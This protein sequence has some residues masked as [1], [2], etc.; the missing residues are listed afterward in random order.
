MRQ[1][2]HTK[3]QQVLRFWLLIP[4]LVLSCLRAQAYDIDYF[5]NSDLEVKFN[6]DV[7][8][9]ANNRLVITFQ[10][11]HGSNDDGWRKDE[12]GAKFYLIDGI[13]EYY[14]GN[15]RHNSDYDTNYEFI[16]SK[17]NKSGFERLTSTQYDINA[18]RTYRKP[19][20]ESD[21]NCKSK[22]YSYTSIT[23]KVP[24]S[25]LNRNFTIRIKG[26]YWRWG[27]GYK[28]QSVNVSKKITLNYDYTIGQLSISKTPSNVTSENDPG[29]TIS[30]DKKLTVYWKVGQGGNMNEHAKLY[31]QYKVSKG[32]CNWIDS[33]KTPLHI[34]SDVKDAFT[35][36]IYSMKNGY[37]D[38]KLVL[39]YDD[40][41]SK[42]VSHSKS[43][44]FQGFPYPTS[45]STVFSMYDPTVQS[46]KAIGKNIKIS[47]TTENMPTTSSDYRSYGQWVIL[48]RNKSNF[49]E[50]LGSVPLNVTSFT[51][52]MI[53]YE[54]QYQYIIAYQY[55]DW[56]M[57]LS[58]Y[59]SELSF[60]SAS[61]DT[62]RKM[63]LE[64]SS[65]SQNQQID[66]TV[67]F[68]KSNVDNLTY[69][70]VYRMRNNE[71]KEMVTRQ[72]L[73]AD[74]SSFTF[75]DV[76]STT[77][78]LDYTVGHK[79]VVEL[80]QN[81][82][83]GDVGSIIDTKEISAAVKGGTTLSGLSAT[84]GT[85]G[86]QVKLNWDVTRSEDKTVEDHYLITRRV[87]GSSENFEKIDL[88]STTAH[89]YTYTDDTATPGNYY[90]YKVG[91]VGP[92]GNETDITSDATIVA[93][94][95][96]TGT[97]T[98]HINYSQGTSVSGVTLKLDQAES[99]KMTNQF[100]SL[101]LDGGS[102]KVNIDSTLVADLFGK[103]SNFS[104]QFWAKPTPDQARSYGV[105]N[106]L[107]KFCMNLSCASTSQN[108]VTPIIRRN[109]SN[110]VLTSVS[111]PKNEW[112]HFS[113]V[114]NGAELSLTTTDL[115]GN[116]TK[117]VI[118]TT[119]SGALI[120]N[121]TTDIATFRSLKKPMLL[122]GVGLPLSTSSL[123][124][125]GQLDEFRVWSKPLTTR[126][127]AANHDHMLVG[128]EM[129]LECYLPVDE[130]LPGHIFDAST[131][132]NVAHTNHGTL[133]GNVRPSNDF[134]LSFGLKGMTDEFGNY[135]IAGVPCS[136]TGITYNV[137][138]LYGTH[139]FSPIRTQVT[140]SDHVPVA[141]NQDFTD[142]SSFKV[143]GKVTYKYGSFPVEDAIVYVDGEMAMLEGEPVKT[144]AYGEYEVDVPIGSHFIS[145]KK[146]YHEFSYN[147]RFPHETGQYYDFQEDTKEVNFIDETLVTIVGRVSG[148]LEQTQLP[149]GFGSE[150]GSKALI[151]QATI[152][153]KPVS[154]LAYLIN[155]SE[156]NDVD[157]PNHDNDVNSVTTLLR[158][159]RTDRPQIRIQT[160]S[161]TG[162]FKA[163]LPP[164]NYQIISASTASVNADDLDVS[165]ISIIKPEL[166]TL[167]VDSMQING[168]MLYSEYHAKSIIPYQSVPSITISDMGNAD[169]ALGES[170]YN[171]KKKTFPLYEI[172]VDGNVDYLL[173]HPVFESLKRYR[174]L[175]KA[176]Q[177]YIN[178]DGGI[179]IENKIP[180]RGL[181]VSFSGSSWKN[182]ADES[183]DD[184]TLNDKGLG[185]YNFIGANP[186][187]DE[188]NGAKLPLLQASYELNGRTYVYPNDPIP[189]FF[190]GTEMF[191]GQGFVTGGP[192]V[193]EFVLRDPPGSNSYA[194]VE[195]GST[196][197]S[198]TTFNFED[199][200]SQLQ[201]LE[202]AAGVK[203]SY[204][205]NLV[206]QEFELNILG[207]TEESFEST[208]TNV[209]SR[210]L[211]STTELTRTIST[212]DSEDF[213]GSEGD[214]FVGK[215]TNMLYG[216][217][218]KVG[219]FTEEPYDDDVNYQVLTSSDGKEEIY[220]YDG[221]VTT[222]GIFYST[223]FAYTA[224]HIE[225]IL[226]PELDRLRKSLLLPMGT[227]PNSL[228]WKEGEI[229]KY[230]SKVPD[231]NSNFGNPE[232][233]EDGYPIYYDIVINDALVL[234]KLNYTDRVAFYGDAINVWQQYL[235][236]NEQ[237]KVQANY[238]KDVS[239][240][241]GANYEESKTLTSG[242][243]TERSVVR[244]HSYTCVAGV[245]F[246]VAC[247][248]EVKGKVTGGKGDSETSE[249]IETEEQETSLT[250]G[251]SLSDGDAHNYFSVGVA[252]PDSI[253]GFCFHLNGGQSSCPYEGPQPTR[254]YM[255][256]HYNISSGTTQLDMPKLS[257]DRPTITDI[258]AGK[259]A[260]MVVSLTNNSPAR[261]DRTYYLSY[262]DTTN[263]NGL[264]M[265]ID[266][267]PITSQGRG[268]SV[269]AG[270]TLQKTMK[271]SQSRTDVLDYENIKL[272]LQP[273]CMLD[274]DE[275]YPSLTSE[276]DFNI[277][278]KPSCSDATMK[279]RS[280][281]D[282]SEIGTINI[283][284][285]NTLI[286]EATDFDKNFKD[287]VYIHLQ[288]KGEYET[289]WKTVVTY[290]LNDSIAQAD[291]ILLAVPADASTVQYT[292]DMHDQADQAFQFRVQTVGRYGTGFVTNESEVVTI[293]KDSS[294]PMALGQPT[295]VGGILTPDGEIS[296]IFNEDI[297][298]SK[299]VNSNIEVM[300]V[301][302]G[303][304]LT[305]ETGLK[306][307]NGQVASTEASISLSNMPFSVEMWLNR[308]MNEAA[309]LLTHG[310]GDDALS[311]SYTA[312]NKLC[313]K[314]NGETFKSDN[315][316]VTNDWQYLSVS[317]NSETQHLQAYA[318][319]NDNTGK[320]INASLLGTK[321]AVVSEPYNGNGRIALGENYTGMMQELSIWNTARTMADLSDRNVCKSGRETGLIA[322]WAM[323]ECRG[324]LAA[325]KARRRNLIIPSDSYW[326]V[327]DK[328]L[329]AHFNGSGDM[330]QMSMMN[331]PITSGDDYTLELQFHTDA[332]KGTLISC[333][334]GV[335]D[336]DTSGALSLA[337]VDG[338][339]NL[340]ANGE[341][342]ALGSKALNDNQWH[343][344]VLNV[345]Q[346][347][348]AIAYVDGIV[349][350]Q[351][352]ATS[353]S[354]L[355][356]G[357]GMLTLGADRYIDASHNENVSD[358]FRGDIDEVR[359]WKATMT[360][361]AIMLNSSSRL[362]GTEKGLALYYP[363]EVKRKIEGTGVYETVASTGDLCGRNT[364]AATGHVT[365]T[366]L[367]PMMKGVRKREAVYHSWVASD[368][369]IVISI[370]EPVSNIE[371]CTLEF[372]VDYIQD[373]NGNTLTAPITWTTFVDIN[374][375]QWG[376]TELH[377]VT[378]Q[379]QPATATV[380]ITNQ[381]SKEEVWTLTGLPA[382]LEANPSQGTLKQLSS[383]TI[384]FTTSESTPIG[385]YEGVVYLTGNNSVD[386]PLYVSLNVTGNVPDWS[387]NPNDYELSMNIIGQLQ[388]DGL[389]SEDTNDIVAAFDGTK[390]VGVSHP[391]YN[392]RY[393]SFF[394][395][396]T[397][398]GN[399][400][401]NPITLKVY[402][403]STG[404]IYPVVTTT[405]GGTARNLQFIQD[406]LVGTTRTPLLI[407]AQNKVQQDIALKNGWTWI[408]L[409]AVPD[410]PAIQT[411]VSDVA[412]NILS[413]KGRTQ[414]I[415]HSGS[416]WGGTLSTME[417]GKM[418]KIQADQNVTLSVVGTAV[419]A[420]TTPV[421]IQSGWN[422]IGFNSSIHMNVDEAFA[423]LDP[424]DGD[425]VK[426]QNSF[427]YYDQNEWIGT[428]NTMTAGTGYYYQSNRT[429]TKTFCY[430][431][432]TATS[433][434]KRVR[435]NIEPL[436]T[437]VYEGN[438]NMIAVVM[439]G[440]R[441]VDDAEVSVF[442]GT[443]LRGYSA[444]AVKDGRHFLTIGGKG[445][446]D[447]LRFMVT[448]D[449]ESRMLNQQTSYQNDAVRGSM[450]APFILQLGEATAIDEV[451][452]AQQLR[453]TL[454][455]LA[456]R[457]LTNTNT[458]G[459][460]IQSGTKVVR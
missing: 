17:E 366:T 327:S 250:F 194:Y 420:S 257:L 436:Q 111:V 48:R 75:S 421:T 453:D 284:T 445:Q 377:F 19:L 219:F 322:N 252:E 9:P 423:D 265:T 241:V 319:Y 388:V 41:H 56:D 214:V 305:H 226:L 393:D 249:D 288:Q 153:M 13:T 52:R 34:Q 85:Y 340:K 311:I 297:Y 74:Q 458:K 380:T 310:V 80:V 387:V 220:F 418:Y 180:M 106:I 156:T 76:H 129:G 213:V 5:E 123:A 53:D 403:A 338:K 29:F 174:L 451:E 147:G 96:S 428:L 166:G 378:E 383:Q 206:D 203:M 108:Y 448:C 202:F 244:S 384:T 381:S 282:M 217:G 303:Q 170:A 60:T 259:E 46:G 168:E 223:E 413:V 105:F 148:G 422:W 390:C 263:P 268:F 215:A 416:A 218:R 444:A 298:K 63:N 145:I 347:A 183:E 100:Y 68:A 308:P 331:T 90:E 274:S 198:T 272:I 139:E 210:T 222:S 192:D 22:H 449:G 65:E 228:T 238:N 392:A 124:F 407:N 73:S 397:I 333:G 395:M 402:D 6:K 269:G 107:D 91:V 260:V 307:S 208:T 137:T 456:G 179:H 432:V 427:A 225:E 136:R 116:S 164:M 398:Y 412:D 197:A 207:T 232:R 128:S 425:V 67:N 169:G 321:G 255:A 364:L 1:K 361:E 130:N 50:Y 83:D 77:N 341:T 59:I 45:V 32:G 165:Q 438:M 247:F 435:R 163:L 339:L 382:W 439:D 419:K 125:K 287:F 312:D 239:F 11:H 273:E 2:Q 320:P 281:E 306:F 357:G 294:A 270:Q 424:A 135:S 177:T 88:V 337:L 291:N 309:T 185:I 224:K 171:H 26:T 400:D 459:V 434:S 278:F 121:V 301:L 408:S 79:Y 405:L 141:N 195:K 417:P 336:G 102:A 115:E 429:V 242:I 118:E 360:K 401:G 15:F 99:N 35:H 55:N 251:Y 101:D 201:D 134:P 72:L 30:K 452:D 325:D 289:N 235:L 359:L 280:A 363:F 31:L 258:P 370:E 66:F 97:I 49:I 187:Y 92:S 38:G 373:L 277:H 62:R 64:L 14:L 344:I 172:D 349:A 175:V 328:N 267:L 200:E 369:K 240:S 256:G 205:N 315:A 104:I 358:Y 113:I 391:S 283:A 271:I 87:A 264:V 143:T 351:L 440:D 182:N 376:D 25:A 158:Y 442:V 450:K 231:T 70:H 196:Y 404:T 36:Y 342:Y 18:C 368:N 152:Y 155:D 78:K 81:L 372:A 216:Q 437:S 399:R 237:H 300:G 227:D 119:L 433:A 190:T 12:G 44:L 58:E 33:I 39:K 98:G 243:S 414:Y 209:D 332:Q 131:G 24:I 21:H 367:A 236:Q 109:S 426:S 161:K 326:Y 348:S 204:E 184:I 343:H 406:N 144:N 7:N 371:G 43:F 275:N 27:K 149:I 446:G 151:G 454:Y 114:R 199:S 410:N 233:D 455:D 89:R 154:D 356:Q 28:D 4:L 191:A 212:S 316:V 162:E 293:V 262:D 122:L 193:L 304:P 324:T 8:N 409:Y 140:M 334:D 374:R 160:D 3:M 290:A 353:L 167:Y 261:V 120:N 299:I 37:R 431:T 40:I 234:D 61:I 354:G 266:G 178:N 23:Y 457:K 460:Y 69:L 181:K 317:F 86:T 211:S 246:D 93:F 365:S 142:V 329:A 47:W 441:I 335:K 386:E 296:L 285:G 186:S 355:R 146:D 94:A 345:R 16:D 42:S 254:W 411:V 126:E 248:F 51:D 443:E 362:S 346:G 302:N 394:T 57:Q 127:I 176:E 112:T 253:N 318:L 133:S 229:E 314:M 375:L 82:G 352:P 95:K 295:P 188:E 10:T 385:S 313:V 230:I 20:K 71:L 292:Y 150:S 103:A 159:N 84:R 323:D 350:R 286:L 396:L 132:S 415:Q 279:I 276:Q 189:A 389:Y 245:D 54:T 447:M 157:I 173:G 430:P 221:N 330:L 379:L 138:P 110:K 117:T